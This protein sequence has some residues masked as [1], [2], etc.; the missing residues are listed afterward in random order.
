MVNALWG[1]GEMLGFLLVGLLGVALVVNI[2]DDDDDATESDDQVNGTDENNTI[3]TGGGDDTVFAGGG[4]DLVDTGTGDDRAFGQDGTD[5]IFGGDGNDFLR[6]SAG[7]DLIFGDEGEDTLFGDSGDDVLFGAD[8]F[9]SEAIFDIVANTNFLPSDLNVF[10][11]INADQG[12]SDTLN[13]GVGDDII[14]AGSFDVVSTGDGADVVEIGDW[15]IPDD[16][17][18]VTDFNPAE[19]VIIYDF[20]GAVAPSIF[21]AEDEDTGDAVVEI[22]ITDQENQRLVTLLGVDFF[23]VSSDNLIVVSIS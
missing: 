9:D 23:D 13:G 5:L 20:E 3:D 14:V 21:F 6:G 11:D 1:M 15:V 22:A 12:E 18:V 19:D 4:N 2:V 17:V 10:L 7:E 8:I 16:P